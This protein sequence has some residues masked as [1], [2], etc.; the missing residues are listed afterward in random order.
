MTVPAR[1]LRLARGSAR[2]LP[3]SSPLNPPI[4]VLASATLLPFSPGSAR[5]RGHYRDPRAQSLRCAH[6]RAVT[7]V[8]LLPARAS[9]HCGG[10]RAQVPSRAEDIDCAGLHPPT[11][12]PVPSSSRRAAIPLPR[13]PAPSSSSLRRAAPPLPRALLIVKIVDMI[14]KIVAAKIAAKALNSPRYSGS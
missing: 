3:L 12:T 8:R 9:S 5:A 2:A 1:A 13:P 6:A 10:H 14:V 11:P 4:L 7:A